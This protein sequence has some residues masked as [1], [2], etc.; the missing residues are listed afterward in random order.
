MTGLE[1][2]IGW[3]SLDGGFEIATRKLGL[4]TRDGLAVRP[5][6]SCCAWC[7]AAGP[8]GPE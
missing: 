1:G 8:R 2:R 3:K 4:A 7:R 5:V 6:D